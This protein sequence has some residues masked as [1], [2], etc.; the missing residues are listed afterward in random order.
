MEMII[1]EMEEVEMIKKEEVLKTKEFVLS[2][3]GH[4]YCQP[5]RRKM[6]MRTSTMWWRWWKQVQRRPWCQS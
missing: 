2:S 3:I 4:L 1:K 5:K 6:M